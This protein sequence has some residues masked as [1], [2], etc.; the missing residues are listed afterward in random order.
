[1]TYVDTI[2]SSVGT[3]TGQ[4]SSQPIGQL[5]CEH[6]LEQWIVVKQL[7]E[8]ADNEMNVA[9]NGSGSAS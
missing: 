2:K 9:M 5:A 3:R 7:V 4:R 6:S 8:A 1:M